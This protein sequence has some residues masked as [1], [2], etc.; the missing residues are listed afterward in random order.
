MAAVSRG[1]GVH[2]LLRAEGYSSGAQTARVAP[3]QAMSSAIAT[4]WQA[5]A[6][7]THTWKTSW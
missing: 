2:H 1:F 3:P 6:A 4:Y 5:A 7:H